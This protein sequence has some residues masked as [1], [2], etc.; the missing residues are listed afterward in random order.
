MVA[1]DAEDDR[2]NLGLVAIDDFAEGEFVAGLHAPYQRC[3]F[4]VPMVHS[5]P[6]PEFPSGWKWNR[7][8]QAA[9]TCPSDAGGIKG[10]SSSSGR[11][12][13]IADRGQMG[14]SA[15]IWTE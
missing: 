1:Q 3:F 15:R 5:G 13:K 11:V 8:G 10:V 9:H 2:E 6:G 4:A 7:S 14:L 12:L